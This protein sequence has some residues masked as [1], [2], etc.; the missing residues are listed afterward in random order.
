MTTSSYITDEAEKLRDRLQVGPLSR[1]PGRLQYCEWAEPGV[2]L[3]V[4]GDHVCINEDAAV[5]A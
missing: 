2:L 3:L 4:L 5:E 1:G